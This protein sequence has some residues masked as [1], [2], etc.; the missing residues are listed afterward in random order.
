VSGRS[1]RLVFAGTPDAAVPSLRT[2]IASRHQVVAV[3]TRPDAPAGRGR[4]PQPSPVRVAADEAGLRVLTPPK[5]S[6]AEFLATLTDLEPDV[7]PVVAYGGLIT[8]AGLAI[9]KHGWVNLHFS[10]LPA[11][12]GAAPVQHAIL[13]GDDLTGATTFLLERGLDTGPVYGTVTEPIGAEDTAGDLLGRLAATG[14]GL[15]AATVDAIAD[16]TARAQP[17][18]AEGITSAPKLTAADGHLDFT[19]PAFAVD[20]RARAVT[21]DP[22]AWVL[23]PDGSRLG[24]GPVDPAAGEAYVGPL[25]GPGRISA[26]RQDVWV[27]TATRPVRL[28]TVRPTGRRGMPA[29]DWARGARPDD[30]VLA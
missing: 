9:P 22:G 30:W 20:R 18:P 2:L 5:P 1:L 24:L 17:Q 29:E 15:L 19:Q 23:L 28:S 8:S 10:L 26:G 11:W 16:G 4:R 3:V 7:C 12:R 14:A 13:A 6:D 25:L 27:G 21:P